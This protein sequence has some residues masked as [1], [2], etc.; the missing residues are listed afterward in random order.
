MTEHTTLTIGMDLGD[1]ESQLCVL[2]NATC[3][4]VEQSRIPTTIA[5][6]ERYFGQKQAARVVMEVGTHSGWISRRLSEMGHE[7]LVA[8]PRKVR[9][10]MGD[11]EKDDDMDAEFMAR[12]GRADP[13]LL[14]PIRLRAEQTQADLALV[15]SRDCVVQARTKLVNHVRGVVKTTG[16][17]LP[18][19]AAKCFHKL[20]EQIPQVLQE[21]LGPTMDCIGKLTAEIKR[22][23]QLIE[24]KAERDYPETE[25]LRQVAGVGPITALTYVLIVEDPSRFPKSRSVGPYLGLCRRRWKSAESD[26]ELKITKRGDRLL[27]RLLVNCGQ[28]ILG[29]YGPDSDLRRWGLKYAEGGGKNAKKR[30]VVGVA[31]RLAVVLHRLWTT[32]QDYDPLY[33]AKRAGEAV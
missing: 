21:S 25:L 13:K 33:N 19:C 24:Q 30:A 1:K 9:S 22:Y 31:R 17:R 6:V 23:D 18:G 2:D 8:D 32:G 16:Q 3:E 15:R 4:C 7:V 14:K 11:D 27:R 26:P 10:L 28:Y 5:A 29:H 20:V 12:I